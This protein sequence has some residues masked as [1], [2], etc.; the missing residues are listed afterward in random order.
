LEKQ[1]PGVVEKMLDRSSRHVLIIGGD[2]VGLRPSR[3]RVIF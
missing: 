3:A 1:R 2:S